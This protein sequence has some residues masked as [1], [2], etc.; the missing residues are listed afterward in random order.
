[1]EKFLTKKYIIRA[2]VTLVIISGGAAILGSRD[3][4]K[5]IVTVERKNIKTEVRVTGKTK[6]VNEV[7]LGFDASGRVASSF[8]AVGDRVV[9]GQIIAK[10]DTSESEANLT[11]EQAILLEE[12]E[13]LKGEG[14]RIESN[15]RKAYTTADNAIR[16]KTDQFFKTPI[17]N[18]SFEV[19]FNDGN[20]VHYFTVPTET[21]IDLNNGR[22]SIEGLLKSWQ[23]DLV[24]LNINN[25]KSFSA[26]SI[27]R[28]NTV[29]DFLN[30]VA[31]AV[32]SFIPAEFAYESTVAGYKT[33]IDSARASV[34]GARENIINASSAG[35]ARVNQ[36][37][38]S[39]LV[40]ESSLWKSMII[41]PFDGTITA[42]E[43]KVAESVA[44][45]E[46]LVMIM[47]E[48]NM[49]V[50]ANVSEINVGK[51]QIGNKVEI[52]LDAYPGQIF[53]GEVIFIDPAETIVDKVVNY[54]IKIELESG[55]H[56]LGT[57][58]KSG[59]T[60]NVKI[61]TAERRNTLSIP[62]YALTKDENFFVNKLVGEKIIRTEVEVGL[63]GS[64]GEI[65][66]LS[67]LGQGD[68]V[69]VSLE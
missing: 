17:T 42:Q 18:P 28:M 39:I 13:N 51:I 7:E 8:A 5:E 43:A 59:L 48:D 58:I 44:A 63:E 54:K 2:V 56:K 35:Q 45:G 26:A 14:E 6:A 38:S 23:Q 1:M 69:L 34:A 36:I 60:A 20:Y 22:L 37:R 62:M 21:A 30:K 57:R 32:N 55:N 40:L 65:E 27:E 41:A 61:I 49:Y 50:E 4:G 9:R 64:N 46:S 24:K 33:A 15:I 25:A 31:F 19:K 53:G 67:G 10:L 66:I 52:E 3:N 68:K 16:N 12:E 29:S 11:K 47:S